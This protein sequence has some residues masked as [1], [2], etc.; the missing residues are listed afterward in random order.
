MRFKEGET[1]RTRVRNLVVPLRYEDETIPISEA[2][3]RQV[4]QALDNLRDKQGVTVRFIGYTDDAPL[5]GRDEST[6]GNHLSLSKAR[7]HRVALAMQETL[8]LPASAIESDGRGASHPL[9]SNATVQGRTL[10]RRIEVEFWY[11][12]PLQELPDEPQLCPGD[13]EEVVTK[14]YDPPWGSIPTLELANGQPI[15]PPGYAANLRRALTDIADRTNP[16]LRFIGYTKNERLDRRTA[17]VYG[18]DIGLSAARARRAM[19]IVMQDP[20]LSGATVRARGT[21]LRPVRRRRER[22][23]HPGRGVVRARAGRV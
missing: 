21:W 22:R 6:Y 15:I 8:G 10:N 7:A 18:D 1:P 3:T 9:A 11:D 5:T 13:A 23:L 2:F 16:R 19:D 14:V 4:R 20:V 17:S 12:D